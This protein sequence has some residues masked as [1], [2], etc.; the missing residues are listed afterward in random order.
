MMR[1]ETITFDKKYQNKGFDTILRTGTVVCTA[2]PNVFHAPVSSLEVLK[3]KKIPYKVI[4]DWWR[5]PD[6]KRHKNQKK[7]KQ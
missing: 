6:R 1:F 7:R 2:D 5:D 4:E 3:E